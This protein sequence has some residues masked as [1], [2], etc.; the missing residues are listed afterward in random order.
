ME[1]AEAGHEF[2]TEHPTEDF[3]GEK[4]MGGRPDPAGVIRSQT[5][6]RN[7]A[8]HMRMMAPALTIP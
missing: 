3:D 6:G 1:A 7:Y 4:E 5:T 2:T 8:M